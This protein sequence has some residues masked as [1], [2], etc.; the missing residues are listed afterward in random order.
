MKSINKA[1]ILSPDNP[2]RGDVI[3][4]Q[5]AMRTVSRTAGG[6][7]GYRRQKVTLTV[8]T[9]Y[10]PGSFTKIFQNR[11]LLKDLPPD[12]CK[13]LVHIAMYLSF[14]DEK[15][16]LKPENV[17]LER[18]RFGKAVLELLARRIVA[19]ERPHWYWVNVTLV[20]VGHIDKNN[21]KKDLDGDK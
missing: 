16:E 9:E 2:F 18:R 19:R 6:V 14:N 4:H 8:E 21:G 13:I 15:I 1:I 7:D 10:F 17:G 12:S 11:E 20:I 5:Q 3:K